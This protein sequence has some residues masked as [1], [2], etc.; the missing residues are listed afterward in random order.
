MLRLWSSAQLKKCRALE[1]DAAGEGRVLDGS[2]FRLIALF[3]LCYVTILLHDFF[4][5]KPK[6]FELFLIIRDLGSGA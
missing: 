1:V 2:N 5:C 4:I 6:I 3:V